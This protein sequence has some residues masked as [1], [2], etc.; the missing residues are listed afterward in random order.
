MLIDWQ[1]WYPTFH[2][3]T[4]YKNTI[5]PIV[6]WPIC[7][8]SRHYSKKSTSLWDERL[9][10]I[11][12]NNDVTLTLT[13]QIASAHMKDKTLFQSLVL[14]RIADSNTFIWGSNQPCVLLIHVDSSSEEDIEQFTQTI[15]FRTHLLRHRMVYHRPVVHI[16]WK[17]HWLP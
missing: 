5:I 13:L 12:A 2:H 14:L 17:T 9:I 6:L 7:N 1:L 8:G 15:W 10:L 11:D 3:R 4:A 16:T